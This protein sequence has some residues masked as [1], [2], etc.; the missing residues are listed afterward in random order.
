M[1]AELA[2][3]SLLSVLIISLILFYR[4]FWN[5]STVIALALWLVVCNAVYGVDAI[6]WAD[7]TNVHIPGWCDIGAC[8][9]MSV[10]EGVMLNIVTVTRILLAANV[11]L[12]GACLGISVDLE[13]I[14]STRSMPDDKYTKKMR[15]I[16]DITLCFLIPIFYISLRMSSLTFKR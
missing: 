10:G 11:A 4:P 14:A 6:L 3:F 2:V 15:L 5:N 16:Y 13:R 9:C 12:P 7:N 8:F 1:H